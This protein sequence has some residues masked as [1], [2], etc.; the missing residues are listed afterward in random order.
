MIITCIS[1]GGTRQGVLKVG[2]QNMEVGMCTF[3]SEQMKK[4]KEGEEQAVLVRG[5]EVTWL[6]R[7]R[8]LGRGRC[9]W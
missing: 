1:E 9:F 5:A 7:E 6:P 2:P 3:E 4:E 8:W